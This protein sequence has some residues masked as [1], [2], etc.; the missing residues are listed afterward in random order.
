M[1]CLSKKNAAKSTRKNFFFFLFSDFNPPV[2]DYKPSRELSLMAFWQRWALRAVFCFR[3]IKGLV[4]L[5]HR[6]S[7]CQLNTVSMPGQGQGRQP[8]TL[9]MRLLRNG[10]EEQIS[11]GSTIYF[12]YCYFLHGEGEVCWS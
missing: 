8:F 5:T 11:C 1:H 4:A 2:V 12:R 3:C 7:N 10:E 6:S 9:E